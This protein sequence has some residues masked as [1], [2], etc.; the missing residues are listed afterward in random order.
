MRL[1]HFRPSKRHSKKR[2]KRNPRHRS[3]SKRRSYRR[4]PS[5]SGSS[6]GMALRNVLSPSNFLQIG[7]VTLGFVAGAKVGGMIYDKAFATGALSGFRRFA[8][9]VTFALGAFAASKT[10]NG[11]AQKA[12]AG[13]SAAGVY[14]LIAQNLPSA[15]LKPVS[16]DTIDMN[17]IDLVGDDS[18][19]YAGGDSID[20]SGNMT[21]LVGDDDSDRIYG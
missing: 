1:V 8:G 14:D 18:G 9:L 15:G 21:E 17:G 10:K 5:R 13:M 6:R 12:A 20:V 7:S 3:H 2:H 4:N 11:L 16:G 19:V